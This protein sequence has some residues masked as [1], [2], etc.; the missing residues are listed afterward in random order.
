[1][2]DSSGHDAGVGRRPDHDAA[3]RET[4][5]DIVVAFAFELE[6]DALGEERAEALAG[7]ALE[8]DVDGVVGQAGVA[9]ALGDLAREHGAGGAVDVADRGG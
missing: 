9:V 3:A 7:G 2:M 6:G 8:A 5:A 4:L 1:M